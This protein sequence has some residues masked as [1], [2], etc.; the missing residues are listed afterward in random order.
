MK[1][2]EQIFSQLHCGTV[3]I[4]HLDNPFSGILELEASLVEGQQL[5]PKEKKKRKRKGKKN[6]LKKLKNFDLCARPSKN[7][8]KRKASVERK[9]C[10]HV[11]N[12]S[13]S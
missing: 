1:N 6:K 12:A 10:F 8:I 4:S 13:L 9:A 11:A 5:Q 2:Q 7:V 3:R